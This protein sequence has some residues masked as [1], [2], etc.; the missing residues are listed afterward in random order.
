VELLTSTRYGRHVVSNEDRDMLTHEWRDDYLNLLR[1]EGSKVPVLVNA[2][3]EGCGP[4]RSRDASLQLAAY[5]GHENLVKELVE[6]GAL[7][8]MKNRDG[9]TA[10]DEAFNYERVRVLLL[11]Q[12][13]KH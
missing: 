5:F 12:G 4:L 3:T 11:E 7:L 6:R 9:S 8:N 10:L 2:R 13:A 1:L